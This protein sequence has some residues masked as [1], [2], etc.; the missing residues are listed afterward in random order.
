VFIG[1]LQIYNNGGW[2]YFVNGIHTDTLYSRNNVQAANDID[3]ASVFRCTAVRGARLE[4]FGGDWGWL[5][6]QVAAGGYLYASPDNGSSGFNYTPNGSWSDARLKTNIRDSEVDALAAILSIPIR[7]Y[8]W[9]DRGRQVMPHATDTPLGL[10]AQ[11][12]ERAI[13][14]VVHAPLTEDPNIGDLK[15]IEQQRLT[16]YLI[17]AI[18][19]LEARVAE[20]EAK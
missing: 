4:T 9:N 10:I 19:Q 8:E 6:L 15:M 14:F 16:P 17:R 5:T 18:Q 13:P 1:G 12:V 3:C 20:L 2:T 7:A 11:E